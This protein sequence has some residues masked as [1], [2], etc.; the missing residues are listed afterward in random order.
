MLADASTVG[1]AL[2]VCLGTLHLSLDWQCFAYAL[3]CV[4]RVCR[5]TAFQETEPDAKLKTAIQ[6]AR[7]RI[8]ISGI[9]LLSVLLLAT[10]IISV[11]SGC[12]LPGHAS[13]T[14]PLLW[15]ALGGYMLL[16]PLALGQ[17]ET[18]LCRAKVV[19]SLVQMA[20]NATIL[21]DSSAETFFL[22]VGAGIPLRM[23]LGLT[24]LDDRLTAANN[25]MTMLVQVFTKFQVANTTSGSSHGFAQLWHNII[26]ECSILLGILV[27]SSCAES[28]FDDNVGCLYKLEEAK[29]MSHRCSQGWQRMLSIFCD[30]TVD[31]DGERKIS[32]PCPNLAGVLMTG[33]GSTLVGRDFADFVV[34]ADKQRFHQFLAFATESSQHDESSISVPSTVQLRFGGASGLEFEADVFHVHVGGTV[35]TGERQHIIGVRAQ[36]D[37]T[38]LT[39]TEMLAVPALS[40]MY[41]AEASESCLS[42]VG[43]LPPALTGMHGWFADF[44]ESQLTSVM[45]HMTGS[46]ATVDDDGHDP[47]FLADLYLAGLRK[48]SLL[49]DASQP[50]LPIEQA[51]LT[52]G[53]L[54]FPLCL[55]EAMQGDSK[56]RLKASVIRAAVSMRCGSEA[57][58][59]V[60]E[61]MEILVAADLS[62]SATAEVQALPQPAN[63]RE[64]ACLVSIDLCLQDRQQA[65]DS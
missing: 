45:Q 48:I 1:L 55:D 26:V 51:S 16:L 39:N 59:A 46:R 41:G 58:P 56:H 21:L 6:V 8:A 32:L 35:H 25:A 60:L 17:V 50:S 24:V 40:D 9:R 62:F 12:C 49:V 42:S 44:P 15:I 29:E 22:S 5:P 52:Y 36:G 27:V 2:A 14:S 64:D 38:T 28:M 7:L 61:G 63:Q 10:I 20:M 54:R 65:H 57:P 19:A 4:C 43:Q 37:F 33:S 53:T 34:E 31:L 3:R 18:T 11:A 23:A 30:A 47:V 13:D